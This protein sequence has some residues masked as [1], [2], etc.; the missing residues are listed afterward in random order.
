MGNKHEKQR[1]PWSVLGTDQ[2]YMISFEVHSDNPP[3]T[4]ENDTPTEYPITQ[5]PEED[6]PGSSIAPTSLNSIKEYIGEKDGDTIIPLH[7]TISL[8]KP[9]YL[10]LECGENNRFAS[11]LKSSQQCYVMVRLHHDKILWRQL[12]T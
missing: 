12:R 3:V 2:I 10:P 4:Q 8:K 6:D 5:L 7:S 9:L 11:R 1:R